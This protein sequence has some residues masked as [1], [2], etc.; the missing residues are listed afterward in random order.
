MYARVCGRIDTERQRIR[1]QSFRDPQGG[2]CTSNPVFRTES[3]PRGT[4]R[5]RV[6]P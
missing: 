4:A 1:I 5:Q 6:R 2:L 3:L